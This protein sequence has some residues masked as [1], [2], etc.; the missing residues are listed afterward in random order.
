MFS[1]W[2]KTTEIS[3]RRFKGIYKGIIYWS[4]LHIL[5]G[6]LFNFIKKNPSH[7]TF[8]LTFL[9][10]VVSVLCVVLFIIYL[11]NIY[12]YGVQRQKDDLIGDLTNIILIYIGSKFLR[13]SLNNL[14]IYIA[15]SYN[16][17]LIEY[18]EF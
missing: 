8:V 5:F 11:H 10:C 12:K 3:K 18:R 1:E 17:Y 6:L 4:F 16:T 13:M 9:M 15:N 7:F 14:Q 2:P